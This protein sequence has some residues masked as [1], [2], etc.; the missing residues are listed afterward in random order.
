MKRISVYK[1]E[2]HVIV[3]TY[4]QTRDGLRVMAEPTEF[5]SLDKLTPQLLETIM[6]ECLDSS[7]KL[8]GHPSRDLYLKYIG[9]KIGI[10]SWSKFV[11]RCHSWSVFEKEGVLFLEAFSRE[12]SNLIPS[13][14]KV[15][16]KNLLEAAEIIRD[17]TA[18]PW[19]LD[20]RRF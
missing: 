13:G 8:V 1:I 9:N 18:I 6:K 5:V 12:G 19:D 2:N 10:K 16:L 14:N 7:E 20:S 17:F 15:E 11:K 3:S 4:A